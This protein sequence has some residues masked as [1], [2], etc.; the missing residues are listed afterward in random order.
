MRTPFIAAEI[1]VNHDGSVEKAKEMIIAAKLCGATAVKFQSFS[2]KR[3][4]SANTPKVKYQRE[5]DSSESHLEMLSRLELSHD[6]Q[7]NLFKFCQKEGIE[8]FSTP[9]SVEDA[10]FLFE[11]G[12]RKF[13]TAS[14]DIVDLP[15]HQFISSCGFLTMV[16]T[17]MA[18]DSEILDVVSIYKE[19]NCPLV[20]MHTTSEYPC[21]LENVNLARLEYLKRQ[22]TSGLGFSDHTEGYLAAVAAAALGA[23]YFEKHFTLDKSSVG[24]DHGASAEPQ[25]FSLYIRNIGNVFKVI[26]TVN[27]EM[28]LNEREMRLVSR[29]SLVF[30]K[31]LQKGCEVSAKDLD[32]SR[33][34]TGLLWSDFVSIVNKRLIRNVSSG[35]LLKLSDFEE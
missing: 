2:A 18:T 30:R 8:F 1:G 27:P 31:P 13:K 26:G 11:L 34:G 5:N 28:S 17:G 14:A 32:S 21:P 3:L 29:K 33:P 22:S 15:L 12:V 23:Q 6:E 9:Y 4:A 35:E 7:R 24:P 25:D 10:H 16:S 20:L 19:A